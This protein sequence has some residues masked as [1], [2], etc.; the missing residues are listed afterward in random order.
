[1][2][3]Q[4]INRSNS[5]TRTSTPTKE[6]ITLRSSYGSLSSVV[7]RAEVDPLGVRGSEN[8]QIESAIGARA[9]REI[10]GRQEDVL[11]PGNM[12]ISQGLW[13]VGNP[14]AVPIQAKLTIGDAGDKYEQEADRVAMEVVERINDRRVVRKEQKATEE[15]RP[16]QDQPIC[17]ISRKVQPKAG[18][19]CGA[20]SPA[21][22]RGL[23][24]AKGGGRPLDPAFRGKVEPV[25]GA[26]FSGVRVH[27][28]G[29]AD[30]LSRSI[31][32]M[33]FTTGQDV[34]F[35]KGAYEPG[36]R[37]GQELLAHELTHVEQQRGS[38][39][40]KGR[41][42]DRGCNLLRGP[43][44]GDLAGVQ[45]SV[46]TYVEEEQKRTNVTPNPPWYSL[47]KIEGIQWSRR[48][49]NTDTLRG[50]VPEERQNLGSGA[51]P[52]KSANPPIHHIVP[53]AKIVRHII[54]R[55]EGEGMT[56]EQALW[57][58]TDLVERA[59]INLDRVETHEDF[60]STPRE[61]DQHID[62]LLSLL[63][64]VPINLFSG[65][66]M[67]DGRGTKIDEPA[68]VK[69]I[70]GK[71]VKTPVYLPHIPRALE[72]LVSNELLGTEDVREMLAKQ[73]GVK[74]KYHWQYMAYRQDTID[75]A[76]RNFKILNAIRMRKNL[77]RG[78]MKKLKID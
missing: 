1:M 18:A 58:I 60:I 25:M 26:D 52:G 69:Q 9:S 76:I 22:E 68:E 23:N 29:A 37:G 64:N 30:R 42:G 5:A 70:K 10:L 72:F 53:A 28:D 59:D 51:Q 45:R 34:F 74:S 71:S 14:M 27:T 49:Y 65:Q 11:A 20:A 3:R 48:G 33:A 66:N 21:F 54:S 31:Q 15:G 35:R 36:S 43:V 39:Q 73:K 46:A 41:G 12:G 57:H 56:R 7:Q 38:D 50:L 40:T 13:G 16:S 78:Q 77:S 4:Y 47:K 6:A 32:A 44:H 63:S 2:T 8:D 75:L 19:G 62:I 24:R 17:E 55:I 61:Y 67:G